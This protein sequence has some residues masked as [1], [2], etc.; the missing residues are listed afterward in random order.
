M[1]AGVIVTHAGLAEALRDAA[2]HIAGDASNLSI[3]SNDGLSVEQLSD[4][5][6]RVLDGL[7]GTGCIVFTDM[8]GGSCATASQLLIRGYPDVRLVT[9]VN[10]PMLVD[11]VLRR[12]D[13]DLDSMVK[14]LLQRGLSSIQELR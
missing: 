8:G 11:F 6:R 9:G 14:R 4:Q 1:L 2:L 12:S 7:G 10:L 5:V 13:L 3:V